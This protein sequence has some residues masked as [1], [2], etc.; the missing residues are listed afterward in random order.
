LLGFEKLSFCCF[1][2]WWEVCEGVGE[3]GGG[4]GGAGAKAAGSPL[5]EELEIR[6]T[7]LALAEEKPRLEQRETHT[8]IS[9]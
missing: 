5:Q 2:I 1:S 7:Q 9:V 6:V 8:P 3:K 4:G